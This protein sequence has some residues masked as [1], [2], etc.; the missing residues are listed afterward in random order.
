MYQWCKAVGNMVLD[1]VRRSMTFC[2]ED[3][4]VNFPLFIQLFRLRC[5]RASVARVLWLY[6]VTITSK[7]VRSVIL[8]LF[9]DINKTRLSYSRIQSFTISFLVP[10]ADLKKY[11]QRLFFSFCAVNCK[12]TFAQ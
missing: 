5:F 12:S 10:A 3:M 4:R 1:L 2:T 6:F 7:F 8:L 9:A 11:F